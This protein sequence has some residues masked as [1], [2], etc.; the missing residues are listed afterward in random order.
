[1]CVKEASIEGK[2]EEKENDV[3]EVLRIYVRTPVIYQNNHKN[4]VMSVPRWS[5]LYYDR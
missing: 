2:E 5:L 3:E 4:H 1:M